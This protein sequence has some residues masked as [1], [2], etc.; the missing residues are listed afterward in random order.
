MRNKEDKFT[1]HQSTLGVGHWAMFFSKREPYITGLSVLLIEKDNQGNWLTFD[2]HGGMI[3][4]TEDEMMV[5]S[6]RCAPD[7]LTTFIYNSKFG[8]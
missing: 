2:K 5:F 6:E 4:A 1:P 8:F 3:L 7:D